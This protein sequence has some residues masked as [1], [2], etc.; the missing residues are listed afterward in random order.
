M[1]SIVQALSELGLGVLR[2]QLY[3]ISITLAITAALQAIKL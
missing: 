2:F 1:A 3:K